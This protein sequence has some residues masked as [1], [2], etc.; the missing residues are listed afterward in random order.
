MSSKEFRKKSEELLSKAYATSASQGGRTFKT[1]LYPAGYQRLNF[2]AAAGS[3]EAM[4]VD[5]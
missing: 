3:L 5:G 4:E 1:R 2:M